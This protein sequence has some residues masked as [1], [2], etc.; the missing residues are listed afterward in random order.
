M[1]K[2][3]SNEVVI[4]RAIHKF[5]GNFTYIKICPKPNTNFVILHFIFS[6]NYDRRNLLQNMFPNFV[7][8]FLVT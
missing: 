7:S 1:S 8:D 3:H 2:R 5:I 4:L 6:Y